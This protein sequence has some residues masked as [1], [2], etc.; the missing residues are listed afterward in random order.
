MKIPSLERQDGTDGAG[1]F[2]AGLLQ[3]RRI[4]TLLWFRSLSGGGVQENVKD[5]VDAIATQGAIPIVVCPRSSLSAELKDRSVSVVETDFEDPDLTLRIAA[6]HGPF[7]LVHCHPGPSRE[8]GLRLARKAG[9]PI[10]MT[11]H[12]RWSD[13]LEDYFDSLDRVIAVSPFIAN[14][15]RRF[16]PGAR[17]KI[18]TIPNGTNLSTFNDRDR[19]EGSQTPT[20]LFS[21]RLDEDKIQAINLL[22]RL[23]QKQAGGRMPKF[24]WEIAGEGP[25]RVELERHAQRIFEHEPGKVRFLGWLNPAQL[26]AAHKAARFAIASGRSCLESLACRV[27]TVAV[28]RSG[29]SL[30]DDW[31]GFRDAAYS[32]FGGHGSTESSRTEEDAIAFVHR[33]LNEP[34]SALEKRFEPILQDIQY[35]FDRDRLGREI[36]L[37]YSGLLRGR[38]H[39][40]R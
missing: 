10:V 38:L 20:G 5:T 35:Y 22:K 29:V 14:E 19:R 36:V 2:G 26:A 18:V 8:L 12:G 33:I 34:V 7:D 30:I 32:N 9:L 37:V 27:P 1:Y 39:L 4:L 24:D 11:V 40:Q 28:A 31:A 13:H 16:A 21:G 6:Q 3:N 23:W 15:I 25:L 17:S